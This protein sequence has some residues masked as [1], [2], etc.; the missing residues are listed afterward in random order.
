MV[1]NVYGNVC[2]RAFILGISVLLLLLPSI[3]SSAYSEVISSWWIYILTIYVP[4][5]IAFTGA[6]CKGYNFQVVLCPY[7]NFC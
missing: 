1:A 7:G 5:A 3:F 4:L 6:V 2:L